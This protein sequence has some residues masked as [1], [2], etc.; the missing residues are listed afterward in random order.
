MTYLDRYVDIIAE[1]MDVSR[2]FKGLTVGRRHHMIRAIR[3]LF[4]FCE[5]QG[6]SRDWLDMLRRNLPK[7]EVGI[8]L[9]IPSQE[10]VVRSLR[11]MDKALMKYRALYNLVLDSGLRL[12]EACRLILKFDELKPEECIFHEDRNT[13][14]IHHPPTGKK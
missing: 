8:D 10:E 4:N 9:K 13:L 11:V 2:V 1:P 5:A 12:I 3:N 7:D 14:I 6:Y